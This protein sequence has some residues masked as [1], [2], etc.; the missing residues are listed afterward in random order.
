MIHMP[1]SVTTGPA[2]AVPPCRIFGSGEPKVM[3]ILFIVGAARGEISMGIVFQ[4]VSS[5]GES[6]R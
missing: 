6:F 3:S 1:L 4:D 2:L 5:R